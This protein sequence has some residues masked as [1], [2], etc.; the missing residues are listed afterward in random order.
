L[1]LIVSSRL[2][3]VITF[4]EIAGA[5]VINPSRV[6]PIDFNAVNTGSRQDN[7]SVGRGDTFIDCVFFGQVAENGSQL[8][9][10]TAPDPN[11]RVKKFLRFI[12]HVCESVRAMATCKEILWGGLGDH[13]SV[14]FRVGSDGSWEASTV[15]VNP[16]SYCK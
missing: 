6:R 1:I 12:P 9:T 16:D 13:E 8:I 3:Q 4:S 5:N 15:L 2:R 10:P 7:K 14:H 11:G